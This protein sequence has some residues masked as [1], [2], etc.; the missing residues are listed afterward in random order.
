MNLRLNRRIQN[1]FSN[2]CFKFENIIDISDCYFIITINVSVDILCH[3]INNVLI[4]FQCC[5]IMRIQ[6]YVPL[7]IQKAWIDLINENIKIVIYFKLLIF[8]V[9]DWLLWLRVGLQRYRLWVRLLPSV[10]DWLI[11]LYFTKI[12]TGFFFHFSLVIFHFVFWATKQ[13]QIK[14]IA[15]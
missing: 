12:E 1:D 6:V 2:F 9:W 15:L 7:Q 11:M 5:I 8:L 10:F 3:S 14:C 4:Y 13:T